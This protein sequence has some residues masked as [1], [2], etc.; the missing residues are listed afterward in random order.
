M[1]FQRF[2]IAVRDVQLPYPFNSFSRSIV[3]VEVEVEVEVDDVK[4]REGE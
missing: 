1:K 3:E 2:Y 4:R